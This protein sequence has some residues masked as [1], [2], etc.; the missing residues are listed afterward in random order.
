[1]FILGSISS[2][3][4]CFTGHLQLLI[5]EIRFG[6]NIFSKRMTFG[7]RPCEAISRR[8]DCAKLYQ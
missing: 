1:V 4:K 5:I 6:I 8:V 2:E 7:N 3:L